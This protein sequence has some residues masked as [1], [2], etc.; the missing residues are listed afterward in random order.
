MRWNT[1]S[2]INQN[3]LVQ[4]STIRKIW[5]N[6]K[7]KPC[8]WTR[9]IMLQNE[10]MSSQGCLSRVDILIYIDSTIKVYP[11]YHR[12]LTTS[13]ITFSVNLSIYKPFYELKE[14]VRRYCFEVLFLIIDHNNISVTRL[15]LQD[16]EKKIIF[17]AS[18]V[19]T[20]FSD[21]HFFLLQFCCE[22]F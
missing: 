6:I 17:H 12:I 1:V 19:L 20:L 21:F 3:R 15:Q 8:N 2:G 13:H 9:V 14:S 22:Q 16:F 5:N 18:I 10:N 4:I 7:L 11:S